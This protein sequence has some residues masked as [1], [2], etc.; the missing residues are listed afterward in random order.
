MK[1]KMTLHIIAAACEN[2]GIGNKGKLPWRLKK[3]MAYFTEKTTATHCIGKQNAVIMGRK[4]WFSIPEKFRP[5]SD[6]I[7]VV[8]TTTQLDIKGPDCVSDSFDKAIEWLK[9]PEMKEKVDKI[10]VIGGETVYKIAM[11]SEHNQIIYLTRVHADFE[12]DSFFPK[13]DT[14]KYQ[15]HDDPDVPKEIQEENGIK[16]KY[17]V[18][19]KKQDT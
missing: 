5:L 7:N 3:E 15:L 14:E 12:C 13:I 10:F 6:R 19:I 2:M 11:D 4:T 1:H 16:F 8:L 9:S 17:E 18:Y